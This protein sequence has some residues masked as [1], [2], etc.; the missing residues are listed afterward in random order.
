M[1]IRA[2]VAHQA[3]APLTM[4]TVQLDGPRAGEVLVEIKATGVPTM[5]SVSVAQDQSVHG[6]PGH[7]GQGVDARRQQPLFAAWQAH[8]SLRDLLNQWQYAIRKGKAERRENAFD[9][10]PRRQLCQSHNC[11]RSIVRK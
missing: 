1:D 8:T 6:D 2:A 3:G 5:Q 7:A 9:A 11:Q 4:E 10:F